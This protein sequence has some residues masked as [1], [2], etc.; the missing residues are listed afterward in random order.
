MN[1][2]GFNRQQKKRV[3]WYHSTLL[4]NGELYSVM[5]NALHND[6]WHI[7]MHKKESRGQ[8]LN[9][10]REK[11]S[12]VKDVER[13]LRD[14]KWCFNVVMRMRKFFC[15]ERWVALLSIQVRSTSHDKNSINVLSMNV[16]LYSIWRFIFFICI[17]NSQS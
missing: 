11:H 2:V 15:L 8:Y 13:F 10:E 17:F 5:M 14:M 6:V 7:V 3:A 9:R 4:M 12:F 16:L 1:E